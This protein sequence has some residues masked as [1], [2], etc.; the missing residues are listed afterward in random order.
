MIGVA[1]KDTHNITVPSVDELK[2]TVLAG[3]ILDTKAISNYGDS[4]VSSCA[5]DR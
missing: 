3:L 4:A 5:M 1:M 2:R